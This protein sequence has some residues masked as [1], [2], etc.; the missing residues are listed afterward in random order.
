VKK[1]GILEIVETNET[2][3]SIAGLDVPNEWLLKRRNAFGQKAIQYGLS[4]PKGLLLSASPISIPVVILT[5]G[6]AAVSGAAPPLQTGLMSKAP[7]LFPQIA[8]G[9]AATHR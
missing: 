4:T 8:S 2:F 6:Y 3:E 7:G 5:S 1:I 9:R